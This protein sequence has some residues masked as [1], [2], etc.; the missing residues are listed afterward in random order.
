MAF[1]ALE[2]WLTCSVADQWHAPLLI[3]T[4][5][6]MATVVMATSVTS[7][8]LEIHGIHR[9]LAECLV[10]LASVVLVV[11]DGRHLRPSPI[12]GDSEG[13]GVSGIANK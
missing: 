8:L 3:W 10:P 5:S 11:T 4:G 13:S 2:L 6:V 1:S 9:W 12:Q 7:S